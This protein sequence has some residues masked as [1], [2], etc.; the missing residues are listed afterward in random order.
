MSETTFNVPATA[1][2]QGVRN[3]RD[4]AEREGFTSSSD[5]AVQFAQALCSG[6]PLDVMRERFVALTS[7][8]GNLHH[9]HDPDKAA[10][11]E[12]AQHFLILEA[13]FRKLIIQ[14]VAATE[15]G[16]RGSSEAGERLLNGAFKAQRAAMAC[17][18]AL[19]V[20]RDGAPTTPAA[21][22]AAGGP[23]LS[24]PRRGSLAVPLSLSSASN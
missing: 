9:D 19:K 7:A 16:G 2:F 18:S 1:D 24:A 23:E 10:A 13:L 20:L 12:I 15:F 6:G 17:L 22:P 21:T 8:S 5:Y 14:S 3:M 4:I 11:A